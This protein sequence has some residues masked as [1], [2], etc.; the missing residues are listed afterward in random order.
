MN[1]QNYK[2]NLFELIS[3]WVEIEYDKQ[4]KQY[5]LINNDTPW[6]YWLWDTKDEAISEYLSWIKDMILVKQNSKN[7]INTVT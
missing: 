6:I 7:E 5:C 4:T 2:K 3:E 1:L